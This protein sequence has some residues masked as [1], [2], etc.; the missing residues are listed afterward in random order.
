MACGQSPLGAYAEMRNVPAA[1]VVQLPGIGFDEAA[2]MM[3]KGLTVQIPV[4]PDVSPAGERNHSFH[5]AAGG[6]G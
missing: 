1:N 4:P 6:V 3:L 5:A 2:A